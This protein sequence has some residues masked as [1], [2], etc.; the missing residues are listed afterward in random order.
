MAIDP[1]QFHTLNVADTCALW[2]VLSSMRLYVVA[3]DASCSFC[4]TTFVIYECLHKQRKI[5]IPEDE[6]LK[7]RLRREA[8][9]ERIVAYSLDIADLQDVKVLESRRCLSKGELSSIAFAKKTRQAFLTDDQKARKLAESVL[10]SQMT[11][12]TPHLFGWLIFTCRLSDADKDD[13]IG[14][15]ERFHRPLRRQFEEMYLE[16]LRCRC[17][18]QNMSGSE[19]AT[20]ASTDNEP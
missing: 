3:R 5:S 14:E 11:Q 13:V 7:S 2:N 8:D 19:G 6:E 15:H 1:S 17:M 4:C 18:K 16:A 20:T 12:T 9:N 10:S